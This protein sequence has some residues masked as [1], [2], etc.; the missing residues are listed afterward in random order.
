MKD[1]NCLPPYK[2]LWKVRNVGPEAERRNMVRGQI[3]DRGKKIEEPTNFYGKHYIECYIIK[4]N[5]C[6]ARKRISIPIGRK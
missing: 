5:E 2:I 6:V 3:L 4:D 1:T